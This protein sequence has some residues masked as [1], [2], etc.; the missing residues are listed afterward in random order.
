M[1]AELRYK[2]KIKRKYFQHSAREVAD[3]AIADLVM[4]AFGDRESFFVYHSFDNEADTRGI[5]ERLLEADKRVY[6]PK[7]VGGEIVPARYYGNPGE[8]S[9]NANGVEEPRGQACESAE[10]DG[11]EVCLTPLLAV[12]SKGYRLGYGGG[13]Y[14]RYFEKNKNILRVG[15]GYFLQYTDEFIEEEGDRPLDMFVCE[16]GIIYFGK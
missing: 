11:I 1:K 6:L 16:R 15:L 5:I 7:T 9:K 14:D 2:Y 4:E 3:G 12:N 13:C 10:E 8:L